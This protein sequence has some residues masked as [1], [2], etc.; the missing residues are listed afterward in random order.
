MTRSA[1]SITSHLRASGSRRPRWGYTGPGCSSRQENP[2]KIA[3]LGTGAGAR[4]HAVKLTALGHQVTV[5]TRDP[6]K[7]LARTEPDIMGTEPFAGFPAAH[8]RLT[9]AT[10]ADAAAEGELF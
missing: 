4:C 5:G 9:L 7:T 1:A 2:M 3:L 10:F 6:K 8:P